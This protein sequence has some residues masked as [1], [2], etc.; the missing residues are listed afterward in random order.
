MNQNDKTISLTVASNPQYLKLVRSVI[1]QAGMLMDFSEKI[2][3]D[4]TLAVDEAMTNIIKHSYKNDYTKQIIITI[5]FY[6][7]YLEL[8]LQDFGEKVNPKTI[9]P[10]KLSEVKPGG[11]GVFFINNIMDTV[12]YDCSPEQGT[13]LRLKKFNTT[14]TKNSTLNEGEQ[15]TLS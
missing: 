6:K 9:K 12:E 11:L 3:R 15:C 1:L 10:R 2:C 7:A 8:N 4:I 5:H 13:I 14:D